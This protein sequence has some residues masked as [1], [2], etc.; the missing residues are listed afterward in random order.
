[1]TPRKS[2]Y[3]TDAMF[4]K[5]ISEFLD[6]VLFISM[7]SLKKQKFIP[8][9][10]TIDEE[11][12]VVSIDNNIGI[13]TPEQ[14]GLCNT[15][16]SFLT[17]SKKQNLVRFADIDQIHIIDDESDVWV[18]E[19]KPLKE[20]D[21]QIDFKKPHKRIEKYPSIVSVKVLL[22]LVICL[23][24]WGILMA[25]GYIVSSLKPKKQNSDGI[26]TSSYIMF[27]SL[28]MPILAISRLCMLSSCCNS[29]K[30]EDLEN[31]YYLDSVD[32][33][34]CEQKGYNCNNDL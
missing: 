22:F 31:N 6:L 3:D 10:E 25:I 13:E 30:E 14:I 26:D 18:S 15:K 27:S 23:F 17:S 16:G 34:S 11:E 12:M 28:L 8:K 1:M 19:T 21:I 4:V 20:V 2:G 29:N 9:L 5:I 7:R 33:N 24:F 32:L